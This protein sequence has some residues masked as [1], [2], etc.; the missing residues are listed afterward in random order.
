MSKDIEVEIEF[1]IHGHGGR[2]RPCYSGY[3][4]QFYYNGTDWDAFHEYIDVEEVKPGD[5]IKA[6]LKFISPQAHDGNIYTSMPFLIREG[7][8]TVGFGTVVK[9]ID[10]PKSAMEK[11][12][13]AE[14]L[15]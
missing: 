7:N 10:L 3:C 12:T 4:P 5:R 6:Y 15:D 13:S 1:L 8:R 11:K 9:I 14:R 2:S